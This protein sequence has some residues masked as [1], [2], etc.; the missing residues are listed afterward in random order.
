MKAESKYLD[1]I[2]TAIM[3]GYAASTDDRNY[4]IL[5][6]SLSG[7]DEKNYPDKNNDGA[8]IAEDL[9]KLLTF[10]EKKG[11][12]RQSDEVFRV[13]LLTFPEQH[14]AQLPIQA[15]AEGVELELFKKLSQDSGTRFEDCYRMALADL[16]KLSTEI[17][18]QQ[19]REGCV[20]LAGGLFSAFVKAAADTSNTDHKD[21]PWMLMHQLAWQLNNANKAYNQAYGILRTLLS[22]K[23]MAPG[24]RIGAEMDDSMAFF[25]R[26]HY[27]SKIDKASMS[28]DS[29][30]MV[31]YIDRLMPMVTASQEKSN[32]VML[33]AKAV[34]KDNSFPFSCLLFVLAM[35]TAIFSINYIFE[36][37]KSDDQAISRSR[38][39]DTVPTSDQIL[40]PDASA[41]LPQPEDPASLSLQ[42]FNRAG[43]DESKP[44]PQPLGRRLTLAELRYVIFQKHRLE[45]LTATEL[46]TREEEALRKLWEEWRHRGENTDF[47]K[48][49][50][51]TVEIEAS[52]YSE[53]LKGDAEDQLELIVKTL[54]PNDWKA[55]DEQAKVEDGMHK[56]GDGRSPRTE[57]LLNLHDPA[58]IRKVL[59]QL[60]KMGY[61]NGPTDLI[62]W[63]SVAKDALRRFKTTKM[64]RTDTIWDMATQ[65]TLFKSVETNDLNKR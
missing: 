28:G 8:R 18:M 21:V 23:T 26:N 42:V 22:L 29:A 64:L 27:W 49:D 12:K 7:W 5:A 19:F 1:Q 13:M 59:L 31:M 44:P 25:K 45:H 58:D 2:Y 41:A 34:K 56:A 63:N 3:A 62:K 37:F 11:L 33:R 20:G 48:D 53:L 50:K 39:D 57:G 52:I 60:E 15:K 36:R 35:T 9:Y 61:Y 46:S 17:D 40:K 24:D 16:Q 14:F 55:E 65:N 10:L 47:S 38:T 43:L 4:A 32:L 54:E 51:E 30:A 6:E